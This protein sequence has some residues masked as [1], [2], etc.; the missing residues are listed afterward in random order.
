MKILIQQYSG[1]AKTIVVPTFY[2]ELTGDINTAILLNQIIY[3]SDRTTCNK[4][5]YFYK[6]YKDWEEE[7]HLTEY[8]V[9]R[10]SNKL[11]EMG[12]LETKLFKAN[13]APTLHYK[14]DFDKFSES[15]MKKLQIPFLRNFRIQSEETSESLTEI[16]TEI[17]TKNNNTHL[18]EQFET[19]WLVYPRKVDKKRAGKSFLA[20][21]KKHS[22]EQ[23]LTG[24]K[25]Y[26]IQCKRENTEQ[27]FIK[28]ASTYLNNEC[29]L[30]NN[31]TPKQPEPP[32]RPLN[33]MSIG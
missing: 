28:H 13:G 31:E 4:E 14:F 6:S 27:K 16:T 32:N 3:W 15:I 7:L 33:S 29:Y 21:I 8:Q 17:T 24:T 12:F 9:K 11:K 20:A 23:I 25:A 26:A 22:F 18:H 2:I 30:E 19:F 10:S 1:Q 5:G